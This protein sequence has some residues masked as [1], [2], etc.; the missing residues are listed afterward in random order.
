MIE[1]KKSN[2]AEHSRT[3]CTDLIKSWIG[4]GANVAGKGLNEAFAYAIEHFEEHSKYCGLIEYLFEGAM[5][6]HLE[7]QAKQIRTIAYEFW[8]V[9]LKYDTSSGKMKEPANC[10]KGQYSKHN[11]NDRRDTLRQIKDNTIGVVGVYKELTVKTKLE[12]TSEAKFNDAK[13]AIEAKLKAITALKESARNDSELAD[14]IC[15]AM[16]VLTDE[17]RDTYKAFDTIRTAMAD[18][19]IEEKEEKEEKAA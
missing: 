4:Q 14:R 11:G 17:V 7:H 19:L 12:K 6:A 9:S 15:R 1:F 8:G 5:A 16:D 2:S 13:K 10:D 3:E 18:S